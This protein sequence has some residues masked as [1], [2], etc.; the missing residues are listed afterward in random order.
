MIWQKGQKLFYLLNPIF[1]A[2]E[3]CI[4]RIDDNQVLR[5]EEGDRT[6]PLS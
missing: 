6:V 3:Q 1:R 4:R 5:P 2:D